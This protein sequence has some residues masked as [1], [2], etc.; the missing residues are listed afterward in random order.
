M[1]ILINLGID[2]TVS[3]TEKNRKKEK[4]SKMMQSKASGKKP[5]KNAE[6]AY[7]GNKAN[8]D[9]YEVM[10]DES[11]SDNVNLFADEYFEEEEE[12]FKPK[13]LVGEELKL[14]QL[15]AE[16]SANPDF[17]QKLLHSAAPAVSTPET[18]RVLGHIGETPIRSIGGDVDLKQFDEKTQL[19]FHEKLDLTKKL[20]SPDAKMVH[21][22][23]RHFNAGIFREN[24]FDATGNQPPAYTSMS[25]FDQPARLAGRPGSAYTSNME[26]ILAGS[27]GV[28]KAEASFASRLNKAFS[29]HMASTIETD[30]KTPVYKSLRSHVADTPKTSSSSSK[31]LNFAEV[32]TRGKS[33]QQKIMVDGKNVTAFGEFLKD[34]ANEKYHVSV[35]IGKEDAPQF[36]LLEFTPATKPPHA[37]QLKTVNSSVPVEHAGTINKIIDHFTKASAEVS[38]RA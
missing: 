6:Y 37:F 12:T 5:V 1:H 29:T 26:E 11:E 7:S 20:G 16:L 38:M 35:K 21:I 30:G 3:H 19:M 33:F 18:D 23:E 2:I 31:K 9:D 22:V 10:S 36:A 13:K 4:S 17:T 34:G 28:V 14:H 27:P 25:E 24:E 8:D 32:L 15:H